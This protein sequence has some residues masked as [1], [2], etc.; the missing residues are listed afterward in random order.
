MLSDL[1][2][3]SLEPEPATTW[4]YLPRCLREL[5]PHVI[6]GTRINKGAAIARPQVIQSLAFTDIIAR[7]PG[8]IDNIESE[9]AHFLAGLDSLRLEQEAA[10]GKNQGIEHD[11]IAAH[12]SLITDSAFQ[13]SAIGYLN[14]NMNAWSAIAQASLDFCHQLERSPS[15]Y[16]QERAG[17]S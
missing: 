2:T 15:Q 7:N 3:F 10:L 13:D 9:K 6:Q 8:H 17:Y 11:L 5:N 16:L 1:P 4:G 12:L 14:N